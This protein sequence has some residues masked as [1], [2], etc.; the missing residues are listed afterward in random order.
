MNIQ[1]V[2]PPPSLSLNRSLTNFTEAAGLP[3]RSIDEWSDMVRPRRR[4]KNLITQGQ[5]DFC[6]SLWFPWPLPNLVREGCPSKLMIFGERQIAV[7][8][9]IFST[10]TA[11]AVTG[12]G[13][14]Q[15]AEAY[16]QE[17]AAV[18]KGFLRTSIDPLSGRTRIIERSIVSRFFAFV[19]MP[20]VGGGWGDVLFFCY[21]RFP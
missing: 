18:C 16:A 7:R 15:S 11:F 3:M 9:P 19:L 8:S 6:E 14:Y 4:G 10:Q 2:E 17:A 1:S 13:M 12:A 20:T 21:N 5:N